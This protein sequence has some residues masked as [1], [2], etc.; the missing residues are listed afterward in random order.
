MCENPVSKV[1]FVDP[2]LTGTLVHRSGRSQKN[3]FSKHYV[4]M[5]ILKYRLTQ[6]GATFQTLRMST[7]KRRASQYSKGALESSRISQSPTLSSCE[8]LQLIL[9]ETFHSANPG[10]RLDIIAP[11]ILDVPRR[12]PYSPTLEDATA[13]LV[14]RRI[15]LLGGNSCSPTRARDQ[16]SKYA[17]ALLSLQTALSDPEESLSENTLC[18]V[19]ILGHVELLGGGALGGN[20]A[21]YITHAGGSVRLMQVRGPSRHSS[22]FSKLLLAEQRGPAVCIALIAVVPQHY[23]SSLTPP[24]SSPPS[25]KKKTVS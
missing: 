23:T 8:T 12:L 2:K 11:W 7:T 13:C 19:A 16:A 24:R 22:G 5:P 6:D 25:Y 10:L 15:S 9:L 3:G 21:S 20:A 14:Q 1:K 4:D 18:A 17:K